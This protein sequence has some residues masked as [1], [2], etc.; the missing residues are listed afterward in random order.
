MADANGFQVRI[1]MG[2]VFKRRVFEQKPSWMD[3]GELMQERTR[4]AGSDDPKDLRRLQEV[5]MTLHERGSMAFSA[6][7][8]AFIAVPLGIQTR[9]KETSANLGLALALIL[10]FYAGITAVGWLDRRPELHPE[11]LLWVPNLSFQVLG[12]WMWWRFGRN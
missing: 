1:P 6:L 7:S 2:E 8:F 12:G 9:R 4:L 11:I 3:F 10:L 5:K